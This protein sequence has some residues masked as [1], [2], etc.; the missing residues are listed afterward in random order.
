MFYQ[1]SKEADLDLE[2]I[3]D[4]SLEQFG[5]R[6]TQKYINEL[7][8]LFNSLCANP[9]LGRK[10]NDLRE[11]LQSTN[12]DSHIIFYTVLPDRVYI[13]RILHHTRDL[14]RHF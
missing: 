1:L 3:I 12:K 11:G 7:H 4:Y 14:P 9:V 8:G 5:F 2:N 13:V 6:Q 10:R